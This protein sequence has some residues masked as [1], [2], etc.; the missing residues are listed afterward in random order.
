[1]VGDGANDCKAIQEANIGISFTAS[2]AALTAPFCT[3]GQSIDCVEK[4]LLE[5]RG[6]MSINYEGAHIYLTV[7]YMRYIM[8]MI[9]VYKY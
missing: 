2:D 5:G 1:M 3:T 8:H 4:V 6:T 7:I 9:E